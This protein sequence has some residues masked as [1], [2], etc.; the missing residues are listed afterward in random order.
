VA[1]RCDHTHD[2]DTEA[3]FETIR[4]EHGRLDILV[5]NVWGGYDRWGEARFD[6]KFWDQPLWRYDLCMGSLR[7]HYLATQLAAPLLF[8]SDRALV[9]E[10]GYTDGDTYLGQVAYDVAKAACDRMATGMAQDLARTG[11][12]ALALHPGFVRTERVESTVGLMG[13][14]PAAVLHSSEYVGR[15]VVHLAADTNV[16]RFS[17]AQLA[18]GDLAQEYGFYDIDGRQPPAFRLGGRRS[19]ATRM[20]QLHRAAHASRA[21]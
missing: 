7:A 21:D 3:L 20:E 16:A 5:N 18:V 8:E 17:G 14:G 10:I 19:L 12:V 6:A 9:V 15:A 13:A 2:P 1:V 4:R 11:V